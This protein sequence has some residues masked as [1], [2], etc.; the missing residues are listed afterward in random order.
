M[1]VLTGCR[2]FHHSLKALHDHQGSDRFWLGIGLTVSIKVMTVGISSARTA[3]GYFRMW[4][5]LGDYKKN[6]RPSVCERVYAE[7]GKR[8]EA[9]DL[10]ADIPVEQLWMQKYSMK[11]DST[12]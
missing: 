6:H 9:C 7:L 11:T 10:Y 3:D 12:F 5:A 4:W 2:K 1:L 8:S